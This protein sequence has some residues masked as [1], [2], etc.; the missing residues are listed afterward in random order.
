M[1][2][3]ITHDDLSSLD[4]MLDNTGT[5]VR[6]FQDGELLYQWGENFEDSIDYPSG[7]TIEHNG[8]EMWEWELNRI[9]RLV[10]L[11]AVRLIVDGDET[12]DYAGLFPEETPEDYMELVEMLVGTPSKLEFDFY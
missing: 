8:E 3:V 12:D 2:V 1:K 7:I 9:E 10:R 4:M 6:V 11:G 5:T